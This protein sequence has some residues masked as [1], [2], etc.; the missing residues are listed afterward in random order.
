MLTREQVHA[1]RI[2]FMYNVY[3]LELLSSSFVLRLHN[4]LNTWR[5][6]TEYQ[7]VITCRNILHTCEDEDATDVLKYLF[8]PETRKD[9]NNVC[10]LPWCREIA[11]NLK[12]NLDQDWMTNRLQE[13]HRKR[14]N[15][16]GCGRDY[17]LN[18]EGKKITL[19]V[20]RET[21]LENLETTLAIKAVQE[22]LEDQRYQ[23]TLVMMEIL[24][25]RLK[26]LNPDIIGKTRKALA[27][28][29]H[30]GYVNWLLGAF[31]F[32][33]LPEEQEEVPFPGSN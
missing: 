29:K 18:Q 1:A 12:G 6:G 7:C 30:R 3:D 21:M 11:V 17:T 5:G 28:H 23:R 14:T 22:V 19:E 25:M 15:F 26:C 9:L 8:L 27:L 31:Q 32:A 10:L 2:L 33:L 16:H 4:F 24:I 20:L 13:I